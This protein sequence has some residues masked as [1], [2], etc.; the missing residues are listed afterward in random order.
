LRDRYNA[1]ARGLAGAAIGAT[2]TEQASRSSVGDF[3][4]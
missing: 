1:T 2:L 4:S 3:V